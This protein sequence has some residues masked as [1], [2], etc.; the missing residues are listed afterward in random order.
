MQYQYLE[1]QI[2]EETGKSPQSYWENDQIIVT[3]IAYA[4][5]IPLQFVLL[6]LI[7]RCKHRST[8]YIE[9]G[10]SGGRPADIDV[11]AETREMDATPADELAIRAR[12]LRKVFPAPAKGEQPT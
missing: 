4:V 2:A 8:V 7:D 3:I 9:T 11:D 6:V 5:Q 1:D 10:G 12:H